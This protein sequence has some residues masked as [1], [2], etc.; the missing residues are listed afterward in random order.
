MSI[1][2]YW[3]GWGCSDPPEESCSDADCP[4]HGW[5]EVDDELAD[6]DNP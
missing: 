1:A 2:W 4:V 6:E 5:P 3:P